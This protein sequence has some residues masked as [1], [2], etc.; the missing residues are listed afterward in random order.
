MT[1]SNSNQLVKLRIPYINTIINA[2]LQDYKQVYIEDQNYFFFTMTN[3]VNI[4]A[5]VEKFQIDTDQTLL[6]YSDLVTEYVPAIP[7]PFSSSMIPVASR[8]ASNPI[9]DVYA[10]I[11][12]TKT[13]EATIFYRSFTKLDTYFSYVG[14]LI[15]TIVGAF[16]LMRNYS[17]CAYL[18]SIAEKVFNY[19][20]HN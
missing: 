6:P 5:Q 2:G 20:D 13:A 10:L 7:Y 14:G 19:D 12:F 16:F 9:K 11:I 18:I 4:I 1:F 15:G 8:A 3:A 17:E